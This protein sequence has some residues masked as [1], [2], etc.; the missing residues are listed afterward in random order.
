MST[1]GA[2]LLTGATW[3]TV[4]GGSITG[5]NLVIQKL[6]FTAVTTTKI[7]VLVHNAL[8]SYSRIAEIEAWGVD[9]G[10][11]PPPS[12]T[13]VAPSP[14]PTVGPSPSPT[15]VVRTNHA[16]AANGGTAIGSTELNPASA[17]IDGNR[18]WAS[19]GAWKDANLGV[20]PDVLQVNFNNV[21][22]IDEI[23][24]FAV[25]DDYLNA[26]PPTLTTT[27]TVYSLAAFEVQYWSGSSWATVPNGNVAGNNKAWTKLTFSPVATSGI[28]VIVNAASLDGYTR[29]VEVEAWG[30][31]PLS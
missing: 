7:R 17:A 15:P 3:A 16:R 24:I 21:K 4:P 22:T 14:T 20:F 26:V 23:S 19:G 6:T 8:Q 5:N 31:G 11:S 28:R 1:L 30:P 12:P 29:I 18:V 25:M 2:G 13:P 9:A 27:T 10:S